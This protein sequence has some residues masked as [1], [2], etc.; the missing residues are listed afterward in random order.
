MPLSI[1][2][3]QDI[4][5]SEFEAQYLNKCI[6]VIIEN[7]M[8]AWPAMQWNFK[9]INKKA[10]HNNVHVRRNTDFEDY[11]LGQKY[12]IESMLFS[13]Y[14]ENIEK[15]NKK[16]KGSYM[17]V[18]NIKHTFPELIAEL[19]VPEFVTKVH[20]GPYLWVARAGHYEFCHI[21]PDDNL[22]MVLHGSKR[23]RLYGCDMVNMYP[24]KL[25]SKG[26]TIQ[27]Q[28]NCDS[29]DMDIF[30]K[31]SDATC[32]EC[33][34]RAGE[35]LFFPAFWWHQVTSPEN[36]ISVNIFFGDAGESNYLTKI[37]RGSQWYGF[38]YWLLNIIEQNR[39]C[40]QFERVL[41]Q[42]PLSL[43][44]FLLKQWNEVPSVEQMEVL[45]KLVREYCGLDPATAT[46][47]SH[48]NASKHPPRLKIR[49]LLWRS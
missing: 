34:L 11:K 30:P 27:S 16:S 35:M 42:L 25:G 43:E 44:N 24:S 5:K 23:V 36:T 28:V 45:V 15:G 21:D 40:K 32:W 1:E 17:A 29:P 38:Q 41:A 4:T 20:G 12:N 13:E 10:G 39:E 26:K 31:F 9:S 7:Y 48:A 8:T 33:M 3:V 46:F 19:P 22:L 37:M 14:I 6:P 47:G 18:Q 2:R 49:G